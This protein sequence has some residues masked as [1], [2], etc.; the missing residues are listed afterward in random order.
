M[1]FISEEQFSSRFVT[2]V[3]QSRGLPK[4]PQDRHVLWISAIQKMDPGHQYTEA[5]LNDVL[6]R[7]CN[8]FGTRVELDHVTLRRYLIDAGYLIR[9]PAGKIYEPAADVPDCSYAPEIRALDL[10]LLL[11]DAER[12]REARKQQYMNKRQP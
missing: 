5:A 12:D 9:D 8:R 2:L 6:A 1:L 10:D 3:T 7:W 4:K 11:L